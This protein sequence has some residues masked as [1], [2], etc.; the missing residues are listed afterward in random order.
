MFLAGSFEVFAEWREEA[1]QGSE[2]LLA[3]PAFEP[4]SEEEIKEFLKS[5][6]ASRLG[7]VATEVDVD[8]SVTRY[9]L[10]SL[11]AIELMHAVEVSLGIV[12]PMTSFLQLNWPSWQ[13]TT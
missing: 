4:E 1:T 9:A 11:Q 13:C 8:E 2:T 5:L 6:F 3:V 10:D 7:T 12:L